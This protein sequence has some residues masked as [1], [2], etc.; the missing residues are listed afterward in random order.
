MRRH[1]LGFTAGMLV[2]GLALRQRFAVV[3][4]T[5]DSMF[6]AL[7]PGDRVLIWRIRPGRRHRGQVVVAERPGAG[8]VWAKPPRGPVG[9]RE[10]MIKRLA[11]V[12][13]DSRPTDSLPATASPAGRLVPPGK[14]V[15]LGDNPAW[16][17][18]SRQFGYV[19]AERLLGIMVCRI[20]AESPGTAASRVSGRLAS[21]GTATA[22]RTARH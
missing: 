12:P 17:H 4:V 19:P 9:R 22:S 16:S 8:G 21:P 15:V 6:P 10:W 7:L 20:H 3:T 13:G 18:D 11:A 14:F 5:G 1:L 2:A